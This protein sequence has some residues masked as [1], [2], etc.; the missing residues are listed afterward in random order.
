[1]ASRDTLNASLARRPTTTLPGMKPDRKIASLLDLAARRVLEQHSAAELVFGNRI[2]V[3][4]LEWMD[5]RTQMCSRCDALFL[6]SLVASL[7]HRNFGNPR[8]PVIR[9]RNC[10]EM[11]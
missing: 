1:M 2:P 7:T 4:V 11:R 10:R 9:C 6:G 8:I 3:D 5:R